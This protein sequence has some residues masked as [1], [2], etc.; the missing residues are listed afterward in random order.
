[1]MVLVAVKVESRTSLSFR[2]GIRDVADPVQDFRYG[3]GSRLRRDP[4]W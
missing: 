4:V 3:D 1:M 2:V